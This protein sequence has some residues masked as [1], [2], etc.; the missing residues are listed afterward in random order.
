MIEPIVNESFQLYLLSRFI[1]IGQINIGD[2]IHFNVP[3]DAG[4]LIFF[5]NMEEVDK[6]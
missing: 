1:T 5:G 6:L 3:L 2:N 4:L